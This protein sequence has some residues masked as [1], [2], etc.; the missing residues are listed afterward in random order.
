MVY[1]YIPSIRTFSAFICIHRRRYKQL[2]LK[3]TTRYACACLSPATTGVNILSAHARIY[4]HTHTHLVYWCLWT[5]NW[6]S[7]NL[8]GD[9]EINRKSQANTPGCLRVAL[10]LWSA[11]YTHSRSVRNISIKAYAANTLPQSPCQCWLNPCEYFPFQR[12]MSV[13]HTWPTSSPHNTHT[14]H[15]WVQHIW[16]CASS[17]PPHTMQTLVQSK[18]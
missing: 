9:N 15:N 5:S 4:T 17:C 12:T 7:N 13:Q 1:S 11:R 16:H 3:H 14:L 10:C 6:F 18:L 8:F 2:R